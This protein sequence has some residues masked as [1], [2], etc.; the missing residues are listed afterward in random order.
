[1]RDP[2]A[3]LLRSTEV[4]VD[5]SVRIHHERLAASATSHQPAR[6]RQLVVVEA[7]Y[8]HRM[9]PLPY[10]GAV[11]SAGGQARAGDPAI[12]SIRTS[13]P[14]PRSEERRVGKGH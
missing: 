5:V 10:Y 12:P 6:L 2:H 8:D 9:P 4:L 13:T 1:M 7:S 3:F 11:I 14:S